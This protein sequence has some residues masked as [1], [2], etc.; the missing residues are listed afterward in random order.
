M[1]SHAYTHFS[2]PPIS[3]VMRR[4]SYAVKNHFKAI[5]DFREGREHVEFQH[6]DR[7]HNNTE[8]C[9][10]TS[11]LPGGS[12]PNS[13]LAPNQT[14]VVCQLTLSV[15]LQASAACISYDLEVNTNDLPCETWLVVSKWHILCY[16]PF[17]HDSQVQSFGI[18]EW[19]H[20]FTIY[21]YISSTVMSFSNNIQSGIVVNVDP[22]Q[23]GRE[24]ISLLS[25]WID[26][27][28][29]FLVG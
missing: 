7:E 11:H 14:L 10:V 4:R 25:G 5:I 17:S 20:T 9:L 18:S 15:L 12:D 29:L 26:Y 28:K 13:V 2:L 3:A 22:L 24:D 19:F 27:S 1:G 6:K 16:T 8:V 21:K 23:T